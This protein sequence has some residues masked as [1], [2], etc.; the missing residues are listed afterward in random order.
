MHPLSA[1][2]SSLLEAG[3][4]LDYLH[5]HPA[6]PWRMFA[7]LKKDPS[8]LYRWPDREWLPLSGGAAARVIARPLNVRYED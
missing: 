5:E 6:I 4:V 2:V 1:I 8:N 7:M 3:L